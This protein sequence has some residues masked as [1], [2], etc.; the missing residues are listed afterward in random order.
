MNGAKYRERWGQPPRKGKIVKVFEKSM[1]R[2]TFIKYNQII[3]IGWLDDVKY[4]EH[5]EMV[6]PYC[7][8]RGKG[9]KNHKCRSVFQKSM[10]SLTFSKYKHIISIS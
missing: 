6:G 4:K 7:A 1:L 9:G 10:S 3:S 5:R 8:E 2:Y